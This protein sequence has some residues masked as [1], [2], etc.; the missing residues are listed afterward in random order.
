MNR[1]IKFRGKRLDN[2][3]WMHGDLMQH[4]DG[5]VLIGERNEHW[6]D[7]GWSNSDYSRVRCVDD[8]T[9]GQFTGLKDKNGVEIYEGDIIM[10]HSSSGEPIYHEVFYNEGEG[11]FMVALEGSRDICWGASRI[12]QR[13]INDCGKAVM[14]NI[15]D[16][17]E[18][19]QSEKQNSLEKGGKKHEF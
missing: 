13:W 4:N 17:P 18:L 8:E 10:S 16:N 1:E 11:S 7:D 15:Y 12:V 14:G 6:T 3:C 2:G 19:L 5:Y 9:V